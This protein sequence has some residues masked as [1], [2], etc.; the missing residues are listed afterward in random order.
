MCSERYI[1]HIFLSS[2]VSYMSRC[3]RRWL[4]VASSNLRW[5]AAV[6]TRRIQACRWASL[7]WFLTVSAKI[8]WFLKPIVISCVAGLSQI[9]L[10]VKKLD[11]EV[12]G[13]CGY[14]CM[15]ETSLEII[16]DGGMNVQ[17]ESNSSGGHSCSQQA[18]DS[19][20]FDE[21]ALFSHLLWRAKGTPFCAQNI[22]NV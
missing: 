12:L 4:F 2:Q 7:R 1:L 22:W 11:V 10:Q 15:L 18:N 19:A 17:F 8:L 9:L 6:R 16:Y 13:L 5:H 21:T 20:W 3:Q 14:C